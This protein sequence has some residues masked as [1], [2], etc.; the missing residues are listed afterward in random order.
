MAVRNAPAEKKAQLRARIASS[1]ALVDKVRVEMLVAE[2]E[3][4][5]VDLFGPEGEEI[6]YA[7]MD[8]ADAEQVMQEQL[9]LGQQGEDHLTAALREATDIEDVAISIGQDLSVQRETIE[10]LGERLVGI[11]E[12]IDR[13]NTLMAEIRRRITFNKIALGVGVGAIVTAGSLVVV[14]FFV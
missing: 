1:R 3:S 9:Q 7:D 12:D 13:S 6:R 14:R 2:K 11:N 4:R 5:K 8:G 10:G